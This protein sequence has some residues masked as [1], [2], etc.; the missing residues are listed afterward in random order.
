MTYLKIK[1]PSKPTRFCCPGI[2]PNY[3]NIQN[4]ARHR[5]GIPNILGRRDFKLPLGSRIKLLIRLKQQTR[6]CR[7]HR[8]S[9]D[10]EV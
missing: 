7:L 2:R 6:I 1:M 5:Y 3:L 8:G 4:L 10:V 9:G